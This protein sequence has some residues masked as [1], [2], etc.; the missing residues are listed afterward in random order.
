[1][2]KGTRRHAVDDI[3]WNR[4]KKSYIS[5]LFDEE[6][7]QEDSGGDLLVTVPTEPGAIPATRKEFET[8]GGTA[9][10]LNTAA[11][12]G[13]ILASIGKDTS[14]AGLPEQVL[15]FINTSLEQI[16]VPIQK[17]FYSSYYAPLL[18]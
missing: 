17:V 10:I 6:N 2:S 13:D 15:Q 9:T 14:R 1:M 12:T 11:L 16:W 4:R 7:S 5:E 18:A 3:R 8:C